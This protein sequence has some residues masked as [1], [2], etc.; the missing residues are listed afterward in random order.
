MAKL[1]RYIMKDIKNRF[2]EYVA[3][4]TQSDKSTGTH[5]STEKQFKLAAFIKE[6]LLALGIN[7]VTLTDQ[8]YVYAKLPASPGCENVPGLGFIA[9]LDTS[10]AASG[11]DIKPQII[12]K[13]S[14]APIRLGETDLQVKPS[15]TLIGHTI[16]T[17]DGTTL[18]GADDKA[19][20]AIIITAVEKILEENISHGPISIAFTP[21]EEIGEG[22]DFFDVDFFGADYAYTVDGGSPNMIE[23]ENFNASSAM[24]TFKGVSTHPGSAKNFM[25]NAQK[26]AMEFDSMLPPYETPEH[27]SG[28]E[29]FYHLCSSNGDVSYAQLNY[30]LRDHDALLLKK[31]ED[32]LLRIARYL[33]EKYGAERVSVQIKDS[34]R[35]MA[36]VIEKYPFL[37]ELAKDAITAAG[38][39]Y[40]Q[41][42]IRGGTDGARLSFM[43]LPCPNLGYG[44]YCAHGETEYV[45]V[46]GM[47]AVVQVLL[48]IIHS[49]IS[50]PLPFND[51]KNGAV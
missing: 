8:C 12:E 32:N 28:R 39:D 19:G 2:L 37:M 42:P 30:I 20:I 34:Y 31:K 13:W 40:S 35:N 9:H 7:D 21:D 38:M 18:L 48:N 4:D 44:G 36:E 46:D 24:V 16:I 43:G 15:P 26:L 14:G 10:D 23:G 22:A 3:F 1:E 11:A 25:I 51:R 47:K 50:N 41:N 17:T 29:G 45:D 33:N 5:P 6:E 49:F 27:T